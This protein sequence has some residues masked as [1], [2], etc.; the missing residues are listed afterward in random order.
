MSC[1]AARNHRETVTISGTT[2]GAKKTAKDEGATTKK[3]TRRSG[4]GHHLRVTKVE[5]VAATCSYRPDAPRR[6]ATA[7]SAYIIAVHVTN[8]PSRMRSALRVACA[9]SQMRR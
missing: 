3:E 8:S 2:V 7:E 5:M 6:T 9:V 4:G 1:A